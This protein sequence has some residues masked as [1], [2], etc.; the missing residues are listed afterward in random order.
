[1]SRQPFEEFN[2]DPALAEAAAGVQPDSEIEGI[3]RVDNP[4]EIPQEFHIVCRFGRIL[5]GRFRAADTWVVRRHSN[6]ISLKAARLVESSD[7]VGRPRDVP[8]AIPPRTIEPYAGRGCVVAEL[9]FGLDFAHPNF[10]NSDGATRV[11][12]F[13]HQGA[14][15]DTLHPNSYGYGRIFSRAEIDAA[16]TAENPY[17][18]LGYHPS[19]S[20]MGSGGHGTHTLDIASGNGQVGAASAAAEAEIV[21]IH[22]ST[23]RSDS[24]GNLGDSVRLLEG[25]DFVSREAGE[26]PWVANLSV[27]RT[28]GCKDG[29]SLVEQGMHECLRM[30]PG[31]AIVQSAGNYRSANMTVHGWMQEGG[32]QDLPWIIDSSDTL[33]NELDIWYSGT[34]RLIIEIQPPFSTDSIQ[35]KLGKVEEI[36]FDRKVIGRVYHRKSDPNN[37]DNHVDVFLYS[38]APPGTWMVRL[39]GEYVITGRFHAWIE[40]AGRPDAQSRFDPAITSER[41]TLG[42]I[43]TSP[44]VI[45]VGAYDAAKPSGI[46]ASFSSQ[47]PTRD[48]RADKPELLAPGVSVVA[49]RST[50][51]GETRQQGLLTEKDGTSMAAPHV[52]GVVAAMFEAAERRLSIHEI[53]DCFRQ[54]ADPL[55]PD[56]H[57]AYWGRL[58][59]AQAI[60]LARGAQ[61]MNNVSDSS[62]EQ[63]AE[64]NA[65]GAQ[66][67]L[68]D[69]AI[70]LDRLK[71]PNW[72]G[73]ATAS[74]GE[75]VLEA[76][77]DDLVVQAEA[78][79]GKTLQGRR[80]SETTFLRELLM[81]RG[82]Q[83][84][85]GAISPVRL[86]RLVARGG[87][88]DLAGFL[89]VIGQPRARPA[90]ELR[91][92]DWLVRATPGT[93]DIGHLSVL[94]SGEL[95]SRSTV[96]DEYIPA[97]SSLPGYYAIVVEGGAYPHD[98]S[99]PFARRFLDSN[100]RVP[101]HSVILRPTR[102]DSE[103]IEENA[104]TQK[105]SQPAIT[106]PSTPQAPPA[107]VSSL[108][109]G[110]DMAESTGSNLRQS[111]FDA[112]RTLGKRF[113]I[114]KLAQYVEDTKFDKNYE[115][116]RKA[117]MIR[118]SYD[119]FSPK[120]VDTQVEWVV[121]HVKRL[122]P[123]DLAPALDLEDGDGGLDR[124]YGYS[125][126]NR[127]RQAFFNDINKWLLNVE[128]R[129]GR[130]PLIYTGVLWREQLSKVPDAVDMN[131]FPLWTA[132]PQ[133]S[134]A[135]ADGKAEVLAGWSDY[136]IWQYAEDT[137]GKKEGDG[138]RLWG[139]DPYVEPGTE[140]FDGIDYDAYG[141]SMY[142]LRGLADLGH[143]APFLAGHL[144][145][146]ARTDTGGHLHVLEYIRGS[147]N[148]I[149]VFDSVPRGDL[150]LAAGDPSATALGNEQLIVYR[151][152][153]DRVHFLT[154]KLGGADT[155]WHVVAV[156]ITLGGEKAFSD[157]IALSEKNDWHVIYWGL[158][159][160][161]VHARR[162]G[163]TWT[164]ES[165]N[166]SAGAQA[167]SGTGSGYFYQNALHVV[168]RAGKDGHLLDMA[169]PSGS[170]TQ[171]ITAGARVAGAGAVPA[172][173]YR[174][175]VY[176]RSL[177]APRIVFRAVRGA[178][179]QI[180]RDT[181]NAIDLTRLASASKCTG[182]PSAV[183][184]DTVHILYKGIDGG[185]HEIYDDGGTWRTRPVCGD[186]ASDPTAYIDDLGHA[187]ASFTTRSGRI[188][189][190]RF[191][192]GKWSCEDATTTKSVQLPQE[193][194]AGENIP[195]SADYS[196]KQIAIGQL[197]AISPEFQR[198]ILGGQ[199]KDAR[200]VTDRIFAQ[201]MPDWSN[202][203]LDPKQKEHREAV[204]EYSRL[205]HDVAALIWL[206]QVVEMLDEYRGDLPREFLL[207]W[208][209]VESDGQIASTTS[210]GE[211][212]YFQIH[213]EENADFLRLSGDQFAKLS[214]DRELSVREGI[215]LV[216]HNRRWVTKY[217]VTDQ[218]LQ[219]RLTKARHGLP[220]KLRTI[221]DSLSSAGKTI[222][223]NAVAGRL[224]TGGASVVK[225]VESTMAFAKSLKA[226]TDIVP[227]VS[228]TS[229][230]GDRSSEEDAQSKIQQ[231]CGF[232]SARGLVA[233]EDKIRETI[234]KVAQSERELWLDK[235]LLS[236]EIDPRRFPELVRYWLVGMDSKLD[237][238]TIGRLPDVLESANFTNL[239]N[240]KLN[241]AITQY[242]AVDEEFENATE[243]VYNAWDAQDKAELKL[244]SA[245]QMAKIAERA[246]DAALKAN[247][248]ESE[249]QEQVNS[250]RAGLKD[251]EKNLSEKKATVSQKYEL[252]T[253]KLAE[254]KSLKESAEYWP[255]SDLHQSV[256][257]LIAANITGIPVSDR[258]MWAHKS[259]A[260]TEPW[261]SVFVGSVIRGAATQLELEAKHFGQD[262]LL[263]VSL[264]HSDYVS[265]ALACKSGQ[266]AA[267]DP[268][269]KEVR[270][271]D[272]IVSD[273]AELIKVGQLKT[274]RRGVRSVEGEMHGDIVV[275]VKDGFAYT[276]GGN[277]QDS[278]RRRRYRLQTHPRLILDETVLFEQEDD[279][280]NFIETV[281]LLR[282]P[283][284]IHPR[285]TIRIFALLSLRAQCF[286]TS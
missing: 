269:T 195:I 229:A 286:P 96:D 241:A 158:S 45:T 240:K 76:K 98:S 2:L 109:L 85:G 213:P 117:G 284:M 174:P 82:W 272:I 163:S 84:S 14:S 56:E 208:M 162:S 231:K 110:F 248:D 18:A 123:G 227:E 133:L 40:R 79:L 247:V 9:D 173:T 249:K 234:V 185:V 211:R 230:S 206:R 141:G 209:A 46:S 116:I 3:L 139:L 197:G 115:F 153:D 107:A 4:E 22:L 118:G 254:R 183:A 102:G 214:T 114:A 58:N 180:E 200:A 124:K 93:G 184:A 126:S 23:P 6:V 268:A 47:G 146:V 149:D 13:W 198:E 87:L 285:S 127:G 81:S 100:G 246:L 136:A 65:D 237:P 202:V 261:S 161:Q 7:Y 25:L 8:Q 266:Y 257:L 91:P 131:I 88:G 253:Q 48:D 196:L 186:A 220:F 187:A 138:R 140:K 192:Q 44:L 172:A 95:M 120:P 106:T 238:S 122:A 150:A 64:V 236:K 176:T 37:R 74:N 205:A 167:I 137:R 256:T 232:L 226:L 61:A 210:L 43:A 278:V 42:S 36:L 135:K 204:K 251:A 54:S 66:S 129:L 67:N 228:D 15:Y 80:E 145:C 12:A 189:V 283:T 19:I 41:Y 154:R 265:Q 277:L 147:W 164:V 276:I 160:K 223:W 179:W 119:L 20:D 199:D 155:N 97:E 32:S 71:D 252:R 159:N 26:R 152:V 39:L 128:T 51:R 35:I 224:S 34:D 1:M 225:N 73:I 53:R 68:L 144:H 233:P 52:T 260:D 169:A 29:T 270:I 262:G 171:D 148:D 168:S 221:L 245:R 112:L 166:D 38:T 130:A 170:A 28:A 151:G 69:S 57:G 105:V 11:L 222:D 121:K 250:A 263:K 203:R 63:A 239:T 90:K 194:E 280:G 216:K 49:A 275:D 108:T 191:F 83:E 99:K 132:H 157:P 177:Q 72:E 16:L 182:S 242:N 156:D 143:T 244:D 258:L 279:S 75:P 55:G 111:D 62:S 104:P 89:R 17:G 86:F 70:K 33:P 125:S 165:L 59:A 215:K 94:V 188:R 60:R 207:G 281:N 181:L 77:M 31:R 113:G 78:A 103:D 142:G 235:G 255:K 178:I 217:A 101:S 30:S 10:R 50:P 92:G 271:S 274:I 193:S 212:G 273:R 201:L 175:A 218:D 219:L 24:I 27:G 259:R 243:A 5:T 267:F 264:R 21:F 190:A 282:K 134:V